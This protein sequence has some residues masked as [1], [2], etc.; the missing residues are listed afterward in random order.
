MKEPAAGRAEEL[1]LALPRGPRGSVTYPS[2]FPTRTVRGPTGSPIPAGF[3]EALLIPIPSSSQLWSVAIPTP[4]RTLQLA[5]GSHGPASRTV[6]RPGSSTRRA[7]ALR[8]GHDGGG[9]LRG[10]LVLPNDPGT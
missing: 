3:Q 2:P 1:A 4:A 6:L 8:G 5:W 10:R 9:E 7:G